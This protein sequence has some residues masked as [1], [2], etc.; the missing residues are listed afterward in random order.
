MSGASVVFESQL[1]VLGLGDRLGEDRGIEGRIGAKPEDLAVSHV[2]RHES[3]GQ[4]ER[5][6]ARL[7]GRLNPRIDTQL[8]VVAWLRGDRA[9]LA[10]GR[11]TAEG[12]DLHP[13][14]AVAPPQIA[15]V[16]VLDPVLADL[17]AGFQPL[18]AGLLELLRV[19]L[20]DIS[21]QVR[22]E[23]AVPIAAHKDALH[24]DAGEVGLVLLQVIDEVVVDVALQGHRGARKHLQLIVH[25]TPYAAQRNPGYVAEAG[26]LGVALAGVARQLLRID[27]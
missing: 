18:V 11:G 13:G 10:S 16:G 27:L 14:L 19:D 4:T 6:K 9:E 8:Q 1:L 5:S 3:A 17:V 24:G 22:A 23:G 26:Q 2:H 25:V 21:E 15:V 7:T 12:V 20:A